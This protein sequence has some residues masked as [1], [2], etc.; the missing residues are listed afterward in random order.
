MAAPK[1][2]TVLIGITAAALLGAIGLYRAQERPPATASSALPALTGT[3]VP[4]AEEVQPV[5]EAPFDRTLKVANPNLLDFQLYPDGRTVVVV[6]TEGTI[7]RSEDDGRT[8]APID[9]GTREYLSKVLIDRG[10]GA[11]LAV[12]SGG[13][14]LRSED[15]ARTFARVALAETRVISSIA[16]SEASREIVLVGEGG[17]AYVSTDGGQHFSR[18]DPGSTAYLTELVALAGPH[19]R[20][21]AAGD[22]GALLVREGPGQWR[23]TKATDDRFVTALVALPDGTLLAGLQDGRMLRSADAGDNW[24]QTHVEQ[25]D[26]YV[27]GFHAALTGD[28]VL[29]RNRKEPFL[30]STDGGRHFD[31]LAFGRET[32]ITALTWQEGTGF[33]GLAGN[34]T[35]LSS[36]ALARHWQASTSKQP[37][38]ASKVLRNPQTRSIL[39]A[40]GSGY[41]GRSADGGKSFDVIHPDLGSLIRGVA[42][43]SRT[44]TLVGVGL[45]STVVRS[46][47]GG[48]TY[49]RQKLTLARGDELSAI[50]FDPHSS[51][52]VAGTTEGAI[53]RS[54][55]GGLSFIRRGA[56]AKPVLQLLALG[57][58]RILA[59]GSAEGLL[60]STDGGNQFRVAQGGGTKTV[61]RRVT[62]APNSPIVVAIGDG[63]TILRSAN[64]G[65]SF[66]RV[67]PTDG[68]AATLRGLWFEPKSNRLWV[69]GDQGTLLLSEDT[70]KSFR[71]VAVPTVE[72]LFVVG[73]SDDAKSLMLGGNAGTLLRSY[74][75]GQTFAPL[76]TESNQP[77]RVIEPDPSS[78]GFVIAG[79][80]GL[81]MRSSSIQE[82]PRRTTGRF[83]GRFD[84]AIYHEPS[85]AML[86][87][88][89]R[90][91]RFSD[92]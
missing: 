50:T 13:I 66:E 86:V 68:L 26:H 67:M 91:L 79:V 84:H 70:G 41:L 18:E 62:R 8:Y 42:W 4:T 71:R 56:A 46:T 27:Y 47:D 28:I 61:L 89:D 30:L 53:Y 37:A 74:D 21:V 40:G 10:T 20:F 19:K 5:P 7:L 65:E 9:T 17:L 39:A 11:T 80:G 31:K 22:K 45:D 33:V 1:A 85:K 24:A 3:A 35:V 58:G 43:D 77:I 57:S 76:P 92:D 55:D 82:V 81:L 88:G 78:G 6:G 49:H 29:A 59:V 14:V 90:L 16:Q 54:T 73:G 48:R 60:L 25:P 36:D 15:Q 44:D 72:N 32:G 83:D 63:G 2:R 12:G 64:L 69:V 23:G 52:F 51:A 34:G 87:F 38:R 75:L